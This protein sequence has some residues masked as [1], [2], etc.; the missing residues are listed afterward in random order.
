MGP[1][2]DGSADAPTDT[3]APRGETA[4]A[5]YASRR[6]GSLVIL[7]PRGIAR[8]PARVVASKTGRVLELLGHRREALAQVSSRAASGDIYD[9]DLRKLVRIIGRDYQ[10]GQRERLS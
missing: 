6:P 1:R 10:L 8:Y 5:R 4:G 2:L 7:R 3:L 9:A